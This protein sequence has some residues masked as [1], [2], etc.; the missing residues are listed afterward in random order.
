MVLHWRTGVSLHGRDHLDGAVIETDAM[1][2]A[3]AMVT[4]ESGSSAVN[5]G[6]VARQNFSAK[7]VKLNSRNL[8]RFRATV[9]WAKTIRKPSKKCPIYHDQYPAT[10]VPSATV[11]AA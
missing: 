4:L 8:Q 5:S 10:P 11:L 1:V 2:A 9:N 6:Q 7:S 3:G